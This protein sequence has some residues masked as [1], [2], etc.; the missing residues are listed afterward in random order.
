MCVRSWRVNQCVIYGSWR[1]ILSS[2]TH[3]FSRPILST[4]TG[5]SL[6]LRM[7]ERLSWVKKSPFC[8]TSTTM[9]ISLALSLFLSLCTFRTRI[10][11]YYWFA[12]GHVKRWDL[13]QDEEEQRHLRARWLKNWMRWFLEQTKRTSTAEDFE[14]CPSCVQKEMRTWTDWREPER[15]HQ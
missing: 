4:Y 2:Y 5:S 11:R 1:Q 9:Y 6:L 14:I 10:S 7:N 15:F 3:I 12:I 13:S 8:G